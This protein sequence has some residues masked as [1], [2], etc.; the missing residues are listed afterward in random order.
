MSEARA[1]S[2]VLF[3]VFVVMLGMVLGSLVAM[4]RRMQAVGVRQMGV[5][6]GLV[7]VVLAVMLRGR[8]MMFGRLFVVLGRGLVMRAAFVAFAHIILHSPKWACMRTMITF[9]YAAVTLR[10]RFCAAD[11]HP[12]FSKISRPISMRRISLVPAPIS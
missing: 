12:V 11:I 1:K 2:G 3:F 6:T 10:C 7:V 4:L 9:P 5:V 8:A